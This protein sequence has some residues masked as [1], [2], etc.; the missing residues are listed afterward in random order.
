MSASKTDCDPDCYHG[1]KLVTSDPGIVQDP[2][3][4]MSRCCLQRQVVANG[5]GGLALISPVCYEMADIKTS[6]IGCRWAL[7][8]QL[9]RVTSEKHRKTSS[10]TGPAPNIQFH[11]KKQR[12]VLT[13]TFS[14]FCCWCEDTG[15]QAI[16]WHDP[17]IKSVYITPVLASFG[18]RDCHTSKEGELCCSLLSVT[19]RNLILIK[20]QKLL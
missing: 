3:R 5:G 13:P 8:L 10:P 14:N 11:L 6:R 1:L 12:S 16:M 17:H 20:L 19:G 4:Q 18:S 15:T 9:R 7:E 2:R